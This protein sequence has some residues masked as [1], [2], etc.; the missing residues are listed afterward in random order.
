M[1]VNKAELRKIADSADAL[2]K[3]A[4]QQAQKQA[5][6]TASAEWRAAEREAE[7]ILTLIPEAL[8]EAAPN[9]RRVAGKKGRIVVAKIPV[10]NERLSSSFADHAGSL[11]KEDARILKAVRKKLKG[12]HI[13]GVE[14]NLKSETKRG[15]FTSADGGDTARGPCKH[16][17]IEAKTQID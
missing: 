5:R 2:R 9:A 6:D 11:D 17:Y 16:Y 1:E 4:L 12:L 13:A 7:K 10:V 14:I 8:K 3:S 15:S